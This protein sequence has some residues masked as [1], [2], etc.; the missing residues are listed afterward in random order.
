M[1][2]WKQSKDAESTEIGFQ[3]LS[4][5]DFV[6]RLKLSEQISVDRLKGDIIEVIDGGKK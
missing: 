1:Y 6:S 4:L 3:G 2:G 5:N